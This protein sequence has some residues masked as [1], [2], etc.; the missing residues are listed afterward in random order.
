MRR[1]ALTAALVA[2]SPALAQAPQPRASAGTAPAPEQTV[3]VTGQRLADF[4]RALAE[5]LA[6]HC[7]TNE[8]VDATLTLAE[9]QFVSGD[10][11]EARRTVRASIHRNHGQAASFPEPVSDL[12][13]ADTRVERHLGRDREA[14]LSVYQILG[15][16]RA[17]LPQEDH[18]HFTARLEIF[19]YLISTGQ[20]ERAQREL[21]QLQDAARAAGREDVA[22]LAELR[23]LMLEYRIAPYGS[24]KRRLIEL[25]RS[26]DPGRWQLAYGARALLIRI[27]G[28][29]GNQEGANAL[30]AEMA[31]DNDAPRMLL[32]QPVYHLVQQMNAYADDARQREVLSQGL[33]T[34]NLTERLVGP[35]DRQWIDVGFWVQPD[36]H[37]DDLQILRH[38]TGGTD[39]SP[40]LLRAI[41]GRLY[42]RADRATYRLERYT[43][44]SELH[45]EGT[46]GS[47]IAA[48]SP[49]ARVEYLD[50]MANPPADPE[51]PAQP[52][53]S[54]PPD[55]AGENRPTPT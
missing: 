25:S 19:E 24:A 18:R 9:A 50:L 23:R 42:S 4:R 54:T 47:H 21:R 16:L 41:Q 55:H 10:Y 39:W 2:A 26:T 15:A 8:D 34:D 12:Y 3:V 20:P 22:A 37:V 53:Q 43:Y 29:E 14:V 6:R 33:M 11:E 5:C 38:G 30:I 40:P 28:S 46:T 49:R 51:R 31:R 27:Y 1:I 17:G 32:F 35:M 48:R 36:G 44:T 52:G 13:R 7:P 45:N